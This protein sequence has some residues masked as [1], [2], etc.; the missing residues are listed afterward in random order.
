MFRFNVSTKVFIGRKLDLDLSRIDWPSKRMGICASKISE[1]SKRKKK[2][3]CARSH[4]I[5]FIFQFSE[6]S[7]MLQLLSNIW[8]NSVASISFYLTLSRSVHFMVFASFSFNLSL[9]KHTS[10]WWNID[11]KQFV[12][13]LR[14]FHL[15]TVSIAFVGIF[16]FFSLSSLSSF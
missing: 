4:R 13:I 7:L 12:A 10:F 2:T 6:F 14:P 5:Y 3:K 8:V 9:G 11:F 16:F 1:E 15:S